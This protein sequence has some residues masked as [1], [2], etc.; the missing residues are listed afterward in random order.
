MKITKIETY[1]V[2]A[3]WKNRLFLKVCTDSP[4]YG[5][6]EATLNGF[7]KTTEAAVNK[8]FH[9]LKLDFIPAK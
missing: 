7:I 6:S 5:I 8:G 9:V 1:T 2:S 4:W 3:G